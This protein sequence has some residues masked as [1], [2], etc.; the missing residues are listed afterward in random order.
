VARLKVPDNVSDVLAAIGA[1]AV[2]EAFTVGEV[3][4]YQSQLSPK[5]PTY[6]PLERFRLRNA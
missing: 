3:V 6:T 2:G 1:E 4:L 5:G